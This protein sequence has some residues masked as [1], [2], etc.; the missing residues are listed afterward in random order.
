MNSGLTISGDFRGIVGAV[1]RLCRPFYGE[2]LMQTSH[3]TTVLCNGKR[4]LDERNCRIAND[5]WLS[6]S[7]ASSCWAKCDR[8]TLCD[9]RSYTNGCLQLQVVRRRIRSDSIKTYEYNGH[10]RRFTANFRRVFLPLGCETR[11]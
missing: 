2:Q 10:F 9:R 8:A 11:K 3:C 4:P 1:F 7:K 5:T 6:Y